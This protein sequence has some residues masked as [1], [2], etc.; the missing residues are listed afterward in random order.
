MYQPSRTV[1]R[2]VRGRRA[3]CAGEKGRSVAELV[4]DGMM[5]RR[6]RARVGSRGAIP[7]VFCVGFGRVCWARYMGALEVVRTLVVG[8]FDA[9]IFGARCG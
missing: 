2:G 6:L 3:V 8:V 5:A 7:T 9:K 4:G 1:R